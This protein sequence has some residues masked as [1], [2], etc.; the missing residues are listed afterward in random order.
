GLDGPGTAAASLIG[1]DIERNPG[2]VLAWSF[3][4]NCGGA[5]VSLA[6]FNARPSALSGTSVASEAYAWQY[7]NG[8]PVQKAMLMVAPGSGGFKFTATDSAITN[9][10]DWS[11][12]AINTCTLK[13]I[14]GCIVDGSGNGKFNG[15]VTIGVAGT[16][17]A[18][19]SIQL[20]NTTAG[21]NS[22][23]L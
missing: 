14:F 20:F 16:S 21:N 12:V 6:C 10:M 18:I 15:S 22:V 5:A 19:G 7:F 1:L 3:A 23:V 9:A 8:S 13:I 2:S 11:G 4:Y 17:G